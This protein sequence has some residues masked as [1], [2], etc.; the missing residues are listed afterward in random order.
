MNIQNNKT[1]PGDSKNPDGFFLSYGSDEPF[2]LRS[3]CKGTSL[4]RE[5]LKKASRKFSLSPRF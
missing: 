2:R 1:P 3:R 5:S 4:L